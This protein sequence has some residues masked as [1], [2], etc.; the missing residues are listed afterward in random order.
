M[1]QGTMSWLERVLTIG[2]VVVSAALVL[3][4]PFFLPAWKQKIVSV[5]VGIAGLLAT[6]LLGY[7]GYRRQLDGVRVANVKSIFQ[8]VQRFREKTGRCPLQGRSSGE[9]LGVNIS[10]RPL[11]E[12]YRRPPPGAPGSIIPSHEFVAELRS[13]LGEVEVQFDPQRVPFGPPNFYQ[14]QF[15]GSHFGVA[16]S[17]WF[18]RP[19]TKQ[20][21]LHYYKYEL[22]GSCAGPDGQ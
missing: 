22:R 3:A 14:Y 7:H 5:V 20:L 21:G 16:A 6:A 17:L 4:V 15:D 2:A 19:G 11:P 9:P 8:L 18:D 12:Q 13:A 1:D 10:N